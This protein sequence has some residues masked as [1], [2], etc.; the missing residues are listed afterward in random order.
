MAPAKTHQCPRCRV[1]T[2]W[3][4]NP[5][6]PFCSEKCRLI[7]LG[8]WADEEY[9]LATN[10]SPMSEDNVIPFRAGDTEE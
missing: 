1:E 8:R 3:E 5:D 10:E 9:R 7:D 4:A 2:T 6:R